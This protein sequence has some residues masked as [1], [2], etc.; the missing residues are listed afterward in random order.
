MGYVAK[1][2]ASAQNITGKAKSSLG[3]AIGNPRLRAE[4]VADQAVAQIKK[5]GET[6]KD[7]VRKARKR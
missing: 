5:T 3:K 2:R 7:T 6:V 1:A 4:G